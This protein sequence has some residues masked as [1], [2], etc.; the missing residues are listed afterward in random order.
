MLRLDPLIFLSL[1]VAME[2]DCGGVFVLSGSEISHVASFLHIVLWVFSFSYSFSFFRSPESFS[3]VVTVT[4]VLLLSFLRSDALPMRN[5]LHFMGINLLLILDFCL[6]PNVD[7]FSPNWFLDLFIC[8]FSVS[9][10][11]LVYFF[12]VLRSAGVPFCLN[13]SDLFR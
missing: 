4:E 7:C 12:L 9:D 11:Y 13:W 1:S 3:G 10:F 5:P 6:F 8:V 2:S